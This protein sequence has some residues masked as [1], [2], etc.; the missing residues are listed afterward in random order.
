MNNPSTRSKTTRGALSL[1]AAIIIAGALIAI[2]LL[3]INRPSKSGLGAGASDT[4]G[5]TDP[6]AISGDSTMPPVTADDHILGNP[7]APIK[8]VE[9]S[10]LS[11]PYCTVFNPTME[12]VMNAYGPGGKVAWVYRQLPIYKPDADGQILHPNSGVQ[13]E[14]L[15]C[16]GALG[17]SK[18][19]FDF[20]NKWFTVFPEDGANRAQAVDKAE[21][22]SVAK[23]VGLNA[24]SFND[25]LSSGRFKAKV[26][27]EFT[28]GLSSGVTGTPF[29]FVV[30]PSGNKIP[31]SGIQDF[32]TLKNTID[33]LLTTVDTSSSPK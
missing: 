2:T 30:T 28:A 11:C 22:A 27:Q 29:T 24:V 32:S 8:L 16:A 21:L 25:C 9:Y 3:Y 15:E 31:L 14:A 12:H 7:N 5:K 6:Y 17:G 33:T 26:E 20:L 10:D 1:P 19:F 4:G 13:A 23:D 18:T